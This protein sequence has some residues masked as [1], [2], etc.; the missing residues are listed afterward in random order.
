MAMLP[1]EDVPAL[2]EQPNLPGTI[3]THPNWRRRLPQAVDQVLDAPEVKDRLAPL[4]SARGFRR[5]T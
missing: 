5:N 1:I 3:D 4:S 2:P